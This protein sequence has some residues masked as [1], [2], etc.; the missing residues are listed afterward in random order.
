M[1][2]QSGIFFGL[3]IASMGLPTFALSQVTTKPAPW[4]AA[5]VDAYVAEHASRKQEDV[6]D[7]FAPLSPPNENII[8]KIPFERKLIEIGWKCLLESCATWN[9]EIETKQLALEF[10]QYD[11]RELEWNW[12]GTTPTNRG[13][14]RITDG[15]VTFSDKEQEIARLPSDSKRLARYTFTQTVRG[16]I[17][18]RNGSYAI[19]DLLQAGQS[20]SHVTKI[21]PELARQLVDNLQV[22]IVAKSKQW[23]EGDWVQCGRRYSLAEPREPLT[24]P[25]CF[26]TVELV[27][28]RFIDKRNGTV[29]RDWSRH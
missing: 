18:R 12:Q 14:T 28:V 24:G 2:L 3:I 11:G 5:E 21:E 9:Y 6:E 17:A 23:R 8:L 22:E 19:P 13:G 4:G 7:P 25:H 1:R 20:F 10:R 16:I 29:L 27:A 26:L 15:F